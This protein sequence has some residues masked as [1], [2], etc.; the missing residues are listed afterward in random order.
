VTEILALSLLRH[1]PTCAEGFAMCLR[2]PLQLKK[3]NVRETTSMSKSKVPSRAGAPILREP[4]EFGYVRVSMKD[5]NADRQIIALEP[6][7]IPP[8]NLFVDKQSGKDFNRLKYQRLLRCLRAGDLLYIKSIDRL[9]RDYSEIIEQWRILTRE[10]GVDIKVLDMPMLDTTYC[11]D[12]L[13]T[14]IADL[15]L[16][17]LSFA[18]QL[19]REN[20]LQRQAEGI[21]AAKAKGVV[22]GR[23]VLSLPDNFAD[24]YEQWRAK[25]L[26]NEQAA[27][28]CG[29]SVRTLY[30]RTSEWRERDKV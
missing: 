3:T 11:K 12:L 28:A 27:L 19:E 1:L 5:Q 25:A 13:G 18:A 21:A 30:D 14:F 6:Y 17:V 15:V 22:F 2:F 20:L 16:Q 26:T 7:S 9:G 10:K 29:F 4:Q 23:G 24:I 8:A